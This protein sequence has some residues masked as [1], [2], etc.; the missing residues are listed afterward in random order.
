EQAAHASL[1]LDPSDRSLAD[2][3]VQALSRAGDKARGGIESRSAIALYERALALAGPEEDWGAR[4]AWILSGL[5]EARYWL[6]EFESAAS[7]LERALELEHDNA[8]TLAHAARFLGDIELSVRGNRARARELFDR[9]LAAAREIDDP[10]VVSRVLLMS[11]WEP[12]WREDYAAAEAV[13]REALEIA[14]ANPEGDR[15]AEAR[16]L[17][18]LASM[19]SGETDEEEVLALGEE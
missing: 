18:F 1:D 9:A 4:E 7:S 10:W 6:G 3:A 14:R 5:G 17:T 15:W 16:A 11:G 8:W 12:Y 13:F 2:R 19:R